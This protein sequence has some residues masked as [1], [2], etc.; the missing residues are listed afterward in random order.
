MIKYIGVPV[1]R[2]TIKD[3]AK[4]AGVSPAAVSFA[5]NGRSGVSEDTRQRIIATA[6]KMGW[7]PN[8]AA[9]ALSGMRAGAVGLVI[10]RPESAYSNERFFF[11][12]IVG[13]QRSL[14]E[15]GLDLVF[16]SSSGLAEEKYMYER[17]VGERKVDGV[18]LIDPHINDSRPYLLKK[19]GLPAVI[20]GEQVNGFG[21]VLADDAAMM[22]TIVEHLYEKGATRIGY[23]AGD[24]ALLHTQK[25]FDALREGAQARDIEVVIADG[26][27]VTEVASCEAV[28]RLFSGKTPPDALV[29][30]NEILAL[31]GVQAIQNQGLVVGKDVLV[32]S[33]ED[34][35][36]CRVLT[37]SISA[38]SKSARSLGEHAGIVLARYF[39]DGEYHPIVEERAQLVERESSARRLNKK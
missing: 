8:S 34:S 33:C 25:R 36:V 14:R 19:L 20:V 29:F 15:N 2:P 9:I 12:F 26:V 32:I 31:G 7:V 37:P 1:S 23:V 5:L 6:K 18:V 35:D 11:E 39:N 30:D 22:A 27:E 3:I 13:L 28:Q 10:A 16:H 17:W 4:L 21:A 38:M 24:V